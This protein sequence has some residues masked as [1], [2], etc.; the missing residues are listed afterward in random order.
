MGKISLSSDDLERAF[1]FYF[2]WDESGTIV[3]QG[4]ALARLSGPLIGNDVDA[5]FTIEQG[6]DGSDLSD[7]DRD[8]PT[9]IV[10]GLKNGALRLRGEV[11]GGSPRVF[12]GGPEARAFSDLA[13]QGIELGDLA[14]HNGLYDHL[15]RERSHRVALEDARELALRLRKQRRELKR[16]SLE[17][18]RA[19]A[20]KSE[21]LA[22]VSHEIRT[23][24]T[25]IIGYAELL[26]ENL[27]SPE[28]LEESIHTIL[29][30]GQG[31]L[32]ILNDILDLSKLESGQLEGEILRVDLIELLGNVLSLLG[33]A[34]SEKGN[35]LCIEAHGPLPRFIRTDP[36]QLQ[37]VLVN[38]V[39]NANKFTTNGRV[40]IEVSLDPA[41]EQLKIDVV[42]S[43]IGMSPEQV[44]VIFEPFVQADA[45][46]TRRFGGSGL[47][48]TISRSLVQAHGGS[49]DLR[50]APGEGAT[51]LFTL[52]RRPVMDTEAAA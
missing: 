9:A 4:P 6:H 25:A 17:A 22:N 26:L 23:P 12:L 47:G 10:V 7:V 33:H 20:A 44:A 40:T 36:T 24:M 11:A 28:T 2:A 32:S 37:Q 52:P 42:D 34:A 18:Q 5:C 21:F 15:L 16:L 8:H 14:R 41:R 1:P 51:F 49:M 3:E 27:G 35:Q 29:R 50:S 13:E 45:S 38:L 30:N 46:T 31:L 39:G 19:N 43:G 48:L